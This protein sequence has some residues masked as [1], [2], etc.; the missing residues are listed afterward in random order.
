MKELAIGGS[1]LL[2]AGL[3]G[4][5]WLSSGG[6]GLA[7]GAASRGAGPRLLPV[8]AGGSSP[9]T[10]A[11]SITTSGL[12]TSPANG[13]SARVGSAAILSTTSM[14]LMTLPNTA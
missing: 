9:T 8:A 12:G 14:P 10:W 2:A 4:F 11:P 6:P 7:A 3:A 5:A 13:P 1:A